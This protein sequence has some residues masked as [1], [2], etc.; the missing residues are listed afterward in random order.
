MAEILLPFDRAGAVDWRALASLVERTAAAG[1]TPAVNLDAGFGA[2][3]DADTRGRVLETARRVAP[4]AFAAGATVPGIPLDRDAYARELERIARLGGTPVVLPSHALAAL[5]DG[6]WVVAH[7]QLAEHCEH[8][9][10]CELDPAF[11]PQGRS[12]ASGAYRGLL[13]IPQCIGA[14]YTSFSR[15]PEWE[16][17]ALR[18]R[19]RPTFRVLSGNPRA[20]D[21]IAYGSDYLLA[22]AGM[23]PDAFARRD[24]LWASGDPAF[25]DLNDALQYLGHFTFRAPVAAYRHDVAMFLELRGWIGCAATHPEAPQRPASDRDVLREI[26]ERLGILS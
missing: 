6:A 5:D 22:L 2:L 20:L 14:V 23:A 24:A 3:L 18:D 16:R 15:A 26:A 7:R 11:A 8:F 25:Q 12:R 17:L 1:L 4:R 10:A 19:H 13:G 9:L 21:Q